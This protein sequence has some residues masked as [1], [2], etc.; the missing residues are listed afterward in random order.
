MREALSS[1]TVHFV[2]A[3]GLAGCGIALATEDSNY[4]HSFEALLDD[5]GLSPSGLISNGAR[6]GVTNGLSFAPGS[7]G[8]A[9][10]GL[11][12]PRIAGAAFD[13][14]FGKDRAYANMVMRYVVRCA[15]PAGASR[16]YLNPGDGLVYTWPGSIGLAPL[17]ATG[18]AIPVVE[19]ELVSAC[20][21]AH[22]DENGA[23][24]S[25]MLRGFGP[26]DVPISA[27]KDARRYPFVE[28][29]F[30][31]N[32][33]R[34]QAPRVYACFIGN[35]R[36]NALV[37]IPRDCAFGGKPGNC[38]PM[39]HTGWCPSVCAA[40]GIGTY[41]TCEGDGQ[42]FRPVV[43]QLRDTDV[44]RCGDSICQANENHQSCRRDCRR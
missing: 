6:R 9:A 15:L 36:E 13:A 27:G 17:W 33:F 5:H 29:A 20:L 7:N 40:K 2:M 19:Q 21:A 10:G 16:S 30:Y 28:G 44:A 32:L 42:A 31:G 39:S 4:K 8:L 41:S 34:A 3:V 12:G 11:G 1:V 22:V 25:I 18:A 14:W 26:N 37:T 35:P 23:Q 24:T 43:V 38:A